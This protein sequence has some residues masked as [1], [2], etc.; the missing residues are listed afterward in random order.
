MEPKVKSM[1]RLV[2][3]TKKVLGEK[4]TG[5]TMVNFHVQTGKDLL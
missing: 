4:D 3:E 1:L 2:E 5:R